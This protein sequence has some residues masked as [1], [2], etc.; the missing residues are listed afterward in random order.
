MGGSCGCGCGGSKQVVEELTSDQASVVNKIIKD[1]GSGGYIKKL[2]TLNM[3]EL[4]KDWEKENPAHKPYLDVDKFKN[5]LK[6]KYGIEDWIIMWYF[7]GE[8]EKLFP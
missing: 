1:S 7:Y 6:E 4:K 2:P 5:L 8:V 3:L